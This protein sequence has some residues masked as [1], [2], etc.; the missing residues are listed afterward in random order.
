MTRNKFNKLVQGLI[1]QYGDVVVVEVY[2]YYKSKII[3]KEGEESDNNII[4][5]LKLS[6]YIEAEN[7]IPNRSTFLKLVE[8]ASGKEKPYS[9]PVVVE[10]SKKLY[11]SEEQVKLRKKRQEEFQ[12]LFGTYTHFMNE[13]R[14]MNDLQLIRKFED[15]KQTSL[16]PKEYGKYLSNK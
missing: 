14:V 12:K 4:L 1:D 8:I 16:S 11:D 6:D 5:R 7:V 10:E 3:L 9:Q 13:P 2:D 15:W